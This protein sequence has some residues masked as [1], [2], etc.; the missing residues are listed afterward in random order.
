MYRNRKTK[1]DHVIAI[2][3]ALGVGAFFAGVDVV[4]VVVVVVTKLAPML[5]GRAAAIGHWPNPSGIILDSETPYDAKTHLRASH[6]TR[7]NKLLHTKNVS[8]KEIFF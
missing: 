7:I 6:T 2:P 4:V 5:C 1:T 8:T 3:T